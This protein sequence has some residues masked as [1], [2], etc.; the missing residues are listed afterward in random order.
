MFHCTMKYYGVEYIQTRRNKIEKNTIALR[1]EEINRMLLI[2]TSIFSINICTLLIVN[3][4][5]IF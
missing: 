2:I 4:N 1:K 3:N 5:A